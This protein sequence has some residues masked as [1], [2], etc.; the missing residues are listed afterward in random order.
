MCVYFISSAFHTVICCSKQRKCSEQ[1]AT[2]CYVV[3]TIKE[4]ECFQSLWTVAKLWLILTVFKQF[5]NTV[6]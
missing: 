6:I 1:E 4:V 5:S 2:S 3:E